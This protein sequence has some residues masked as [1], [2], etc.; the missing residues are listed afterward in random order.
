MH[1]ILKG[2]FFSG[3]RRHTRSSTVSWLGDVYKRQSENVTRQS[4]KAIE[5]L[6]GQ[7]DLLKNVSENLVNQIASVTNRFDSQGQTI[8]VSYTHLT[9]PTIYSV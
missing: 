2:F 5:G 8:P 3:R 7:A 6:A 4:V 9:L 1:L